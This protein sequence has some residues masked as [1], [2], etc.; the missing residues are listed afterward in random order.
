MNTVQKHA[1]TES[2]AQES[3]DVDVPTEVNE[4]SQEVLDA[5]DSC[6]AEIDAV[7]E[8]HEDDWL[9]GP[10]PGDPME[11]ADAAGRKA[12]QECLGT[13]DE[14]DAAYEEAFSAAYIIAKARIEEWHEHR[15]L[16]Y[17]PCVCG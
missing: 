3:V 16:T 6:L 10:K 15:G 11:I 8:E 13:P 12:E 14:K 2:T 4:T 7:L 1:Q 17:N 5:C 9:N